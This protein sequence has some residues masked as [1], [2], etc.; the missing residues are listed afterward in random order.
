MNSI[1]LTLIVITPAYILGSINGAIITS[2]I[3]YRKDIRKFGSG[4]A[5]LT[6][7]YRTFGKGGALLVI[8]IDALK[9]MIPVIFGGWLF[10]VFTDMPVSETWL[11]KHFF[12]VSI[13]GLLLSGLFVMIGHCFPVFYKFKGGKGVMAAGVMVLMLDWR[14]AV[15]CFAMF[16]LFTYSTRFV[17]LGAILSCSFIPFVQYFILGLG[18]IRE[19]LIALL[20][21]GLVVI[22]HESNIKRLIKG[23]ESQTNY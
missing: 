7:F 19:F 13:F 8:F 17:S 1:F 4:N 5:G 6:N 21:A 23:E 20:C 9:T 10:T 18:G 2:H 22:R 14:L 11:L 16:A 12:N 15:I 3:F